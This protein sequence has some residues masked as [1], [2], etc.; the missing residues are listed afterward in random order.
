MLCLTLIAALFLI[1]LPRCRAEYAASLYDVTASNVL[2]YSEGIAWIQYGPGPTTAAVDEDGDVLF[3]LPEGEFIEYLSPFSGGSAFYV[4]NDGE[5]VHEVIVDT[6][7]NLTWSTDL[8]GDTHILANGDGVFVIQRHIS[9]FEADELSVGAVDL[10]GNT[11]CEP[12]HRIGE[13]V[14]DEDNSLG[15]KVHSRLAYPSDN[16]FSVAYGKSRFQREDAPKCY[17]LGDGAF[18]LSSNTLY[19][20]TA[21]V[22]FVNPGT[23]D[24]FTYKRV[25][26][27][28]GRFRTV[29]TN[30]SGHP[31]VPAFSLYDTDLNLLSVFSDRNCVQQA[32]DQLNLPEV[33][34][35]RTYSEQKDYI[36]THYERFWYQDG[37][38]YLYHCYWN[39]EDTIALHIPEYTD[40]SM[41][42]GPFY[43]GRAVLWVEGADGKRYLT[44]IDETG[45][46]Q[47]APIR[48]E[49]S[50]FTIWEGLFLAKDEN[51]NWNLYDIEGNLRH[52]VSDDFEVIT[53]DNEFGDIINGFI[54]VRY[55]DKNAMTLYSVRDA[56][57]D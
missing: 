50:Y 3:T 6:E 2:P 8:G 9:G 25:L 52:C 34:W 48:V 29:S 10:Y 36:T 22:L 18:Y 41:L 56:V 12:K 51:R 19:N 47:F 26:A 32:N 27:T 30:Y 21:S 28:N 1:P 24:N 42:G 55:S 20:P 17:Y 7:G 40:R 31:V 38:Y 5:S 33:G 44:V 23:A 35:T 37:L 45:A 54:S 15:R 4:A 13:T 46:F 39:D 49:T 57:D 11:I 16:Y 43:D 14:Y 53:H